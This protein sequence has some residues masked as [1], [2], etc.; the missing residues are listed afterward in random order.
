MYYETGQYG[1]FDSLQNRRTVMDLFRR[2]G[3]GVP[4]DVACKRRGKFL[5]SLLEASQ[6][7]FAGKASQMSPCDTVDAYLAFG[8]ITGV[9]GVDVDEAARSWSEW[10]RGRRSERRAD[11][12]RPSILDPRRPS[13]EG[14]L[15]RSTV[16]TSAPTANPPPAAAMCTLRFTTVASARPTTTA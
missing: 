2:L 4:Y 10:W 1:S 13:H 5:Q 6:N 15:R 3:D 16:P 8:A 14:R 12:R 9:L 7:G 11:D